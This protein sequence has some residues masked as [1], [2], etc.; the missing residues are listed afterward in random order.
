M[1]PEELEVLVGIDV[2][3]YF[4]ESIIDHEERGRNVKNW[5][6]RIDGRDMSQMKIHG[7]IGIRSKTWPHWTS[8][9]KIIRNSNW[10]ESIG[11]I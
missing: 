11:K 3:E 6:F 5:K 1:T 9:V 7:S 2:D 10:A 8:T 4:V